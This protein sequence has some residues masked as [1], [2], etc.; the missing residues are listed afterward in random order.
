MVSPERGSKATARMRLA[1]L[2][3]GICGVLTASVRMNSAGV[4]LLDVSLLSVSF[5]MV[6]WAVLEGLRTR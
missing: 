1:I 4:G 6:A 3:V 5:V 2:V